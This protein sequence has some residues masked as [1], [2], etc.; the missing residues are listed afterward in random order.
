[1]VS[2]DIAPGQVSRPR[3]GIDNN[4]VNY[5]LK[6]FGVTTVI[7]AH[8]ARGKEV[9][10]CNRCHSFRW[11]QWIRWIRRKLTEGVILKHTHTFAD[12]CWKIIARNLFLNN[13]L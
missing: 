13:T 9:R 1:M 8:A 10:T 6:E 12:F 3:A 5:D 4:I 7:L 11:I 2:Y